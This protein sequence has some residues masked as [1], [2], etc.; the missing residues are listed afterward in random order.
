MVGR[1][2]ID[3]YLRTSREKKSRHTLDEADGQRDRHRLSV[4]WFKLKDVCYFYDPTA[5]TTDTFSIRDSNFLASATEGMGRHN[6][7]RGHE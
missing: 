6:I 3:I 7:H 2:D 1:S 5:V 4:Q